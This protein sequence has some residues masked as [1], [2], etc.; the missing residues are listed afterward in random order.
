M[1]ARS[2]LILPLALTLSACEDKHQDHDHDHDHD[3]DM[4]M[5]DTDTSMD[6]AMGY[7]DGMTATTAGGHF[8]V[9]LTL[10][11]GGVHGTQDVTLDIAHHGA[12]SAGL[13]VDLVATMPMHGHGTNDVTVTETMDAGTY[14]AEG[15]ELTMAGVWK[16][17]VTVN[18]PGHGGDAVFLIQID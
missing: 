1:F 11:G 17:A 3:S 14:R 5:G 13:D 4:Q 10:S 18:E 6:D 15:L 8:E 2:S 12:A 9:A 7:V 16:L